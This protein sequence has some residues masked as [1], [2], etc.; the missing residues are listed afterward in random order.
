M[1][2]KGN[3]ITIEIGA[4][5]ET[6]AKN[7]ERVSS[8]LKGLRDSSKGKFSN[9][10]K[11]ASELSEVARVSREMEDSVGALAKTA[12]ALERLSNLKSISI[13][14]SIGDSIRNIGLASESL[15]PG[16]VETVDSLTK[17]LQRLSNVDFST[18]SE[19]KGIRLPNIPESA[20]AAIREMVEAINQ[21]TPESMARI[22]ELADHLS[23]LNNVDL[24]GLS[25]V[26][27]NVNSQNTRVRVDSSDV[28]KASKRV[29]TLSKTLS[30]L[31]RIAFYRIIR[32]A[33]KSVTDAFQEGLKNAYA[34][35]QGIIT[36]GHRF[37]TALDAMSTSS[38]MMKNQLG[39]AFISLLAAIAPIVNQIIGLVVRLADALSQFFAA[40]TGGTYLKAV[41]FPQKWADGAGGAAK[42]AKEWKNQLLGF[43]EINRLE[44][45]SDTG[46]GG[47]GGSG[48][49]ASQMFVDTPIDGIFAKI[50]DKLLELK[51]S[52]DFEPLKRSWEGFKESVIG[53]AE[54]IG[55]ALG[56]LWDNIA[57][58]F[59]KWTIESAF[60]AI[61]NLASAVI[62]LANTILQILGPVIDW[63]W[64][65]ILKPVVTYIG[66]VF[67]GTLKDLTKFLRDLNS[68]LNG[69]ISF[70]EF[71]E[72]FFKSDLAIKGFQE[73]LSHALVDGKLNW[74]DFAAVAL[75][76]IMQP[77]NAI[78]TL[79]NWIITAVQWIERLANEWNG[80]REGIGA[81]SAKAGSEKFGFGVFATGG[82]PESGQ[83]F[84]AREAGPELVGTMGGRTAVANNDQI[85][86][87]I[88]M[89]VYEA[90]TAAMSTAGGGET[91]VKV[92]L[93]SREIKAG[94]NRLN[95]AL[96]VG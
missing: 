42:A 54:T 17:F 62:D 74:M 31:K 2:V 68:F 12:Q 14:K 19:L 52:I 23:K 25:L 94:Q 20:G 1:Q 82:F 84:M 72:G 26:L 81:A 47:G 95:R 90:V 92:Y 75:N 57:A 3:D 30:A 5:S 69:E 58:P 49:D 64:N 29:S 66:E 83:L 73:T 37:S 22:G 76:S 7:I 8:A 15:S 39:S 87:G 61:L 36:E 43:D 85:V 45:P 78:I 65:N 32:S 28:D 96:G 60:P 89:G 4:S 13:P 44:E 59:I 70:K 86:E 6:A 38:L 16:A 33:I 48:L 41:N 79:I 88:R 35:S 77:I 80:M 11:I 46:R 18:L 55:K 10:S 71:I 91:V 34:F 53:L 67:I 21:I 50:R 24:S 93:D 27:R 56:W 63:I 9:L 51:N 40:F